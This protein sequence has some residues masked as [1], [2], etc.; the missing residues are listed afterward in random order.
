MI[1]ASGIIKQILSGTM[2][3]HELMRDV[4][5]MEQFS[6]GTTNYNFVVNV[7][8][9]MG[10]RVVLNG[11]NVTVAPVDQKVDTVLP[12]F[13]R[14]RKN[15]ALQHIRNEPFMFLPE[16][17]EV[18]ARLEIMFH[19][20][21]AQPLTG[22]AYRE[23]MSLKEIK[24]TSTKH[25]IPQMMV[26]IPVLCLTDSTIRLVRVSL[27]NLTTKIERSVIEG[28]CCIVKGKASRRTIVTPSM[29]F[30]SSVSPEQAIAN[31]QAGLKQV[32]DEYTQPNVFTAAQAQTLR[33]ILDTRTRDPQ[34]IQALMRRVAPSLTINE[35][36]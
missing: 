34:A 12:E 25:S 9:A 29:A 15:P 4:A 6:S 11:V 14:V 1:N 19:G 35:G 31:A 36:Q 20:T 18:Y 23:V 16:L 3:V 24:S 32:H 7:L 21:E 22:A 27:F 30:D 33:N 5:T 2:T 17:D 13:M 26:A 8:L 28:K 10:V